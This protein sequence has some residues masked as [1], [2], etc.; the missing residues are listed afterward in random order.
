[1]PEAESTVIAQSEAAHERGGMPQL[2]PDYV[3]PQLFWLVVS[4]ALLYLLMSRVALPRIAAVME[5]RR[6]K[7]AR[8]LDR[9]E[10]LKKEADAAL[11]NYEKA[12]AEARARAQ[13]IT[14][15]TRAKLKA[16]TDRLRAELDGKL[17]ARASEAEAR[18]RRA[19]EAALA[20]LKPAVSEVAAAIVSKLLG[21]AVEAETADRALE[22]A[23]KGD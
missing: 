7:I 19:K 4:F 2:N 23:L 13:S 5:E 6:D 22:A 20:N 9:A 14:A 8:D 16:E 12:L 21:E 18:I 10:S 11:A 15:E 3:A 17:A 1:V